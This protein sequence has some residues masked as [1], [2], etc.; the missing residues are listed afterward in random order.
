MKNCIYT[1]TCALGVF[2]MLAGCATQSGTEDQFG[3]AVRAVTAAQVAD[4]SATAYR[5]DEAVSGGDS[6]RLENVVIMHRGD[7][8]KPADVR[9]P[10]V[11][12]PNT[13][14]R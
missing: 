2:V 8:S 6:Y 7:V 11:V 10:M 12:G 3:D 9:K 1:T 5:R 13:S 4:P 14:E